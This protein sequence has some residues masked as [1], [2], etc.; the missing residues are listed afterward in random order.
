MD[1]PIGEQRPFPAEIFHKSLDTADL[2]GRDP[3]LQKSNG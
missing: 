2:F 1:D 3:L